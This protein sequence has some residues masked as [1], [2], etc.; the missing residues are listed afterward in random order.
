MK[1]TDE[2]GSQLRRESGVIKLRR[3]HANLSGWTSRISKK[4]YIVGTELG[5]DA[6]HGKILTVID[7][8]NVNYWFD[9]DRQDAENKALHDD[10]KVRIKLSGLHD[11]ASMFSQQLRFYYGHDPQNQES[12]R[13][14]AAT[15]A[16][17]LTTRS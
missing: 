4:E 3:F 1:C 13:F 2:C 5:I 17:V 14:L 6:S 16:H 12:L 10:E 9:D 8:G 7:F 15:Q 11:F